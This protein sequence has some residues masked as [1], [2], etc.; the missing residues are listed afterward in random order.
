MGKGRSRQGYFGQEMVADCDVSRVYVSVDN[1]Y[2]K[3][4]LVTGN[5]L[6]LMV[7]GRKEGRKNFFNEG[8]VVGKRQVSDG[9]RQ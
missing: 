1:G 5:T 3:G 8:R 6:G 9:E 2:R 4:R 7:V